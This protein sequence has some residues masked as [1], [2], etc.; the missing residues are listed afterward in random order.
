MSKKAVRD[1]LH[2]VWSH[3][4]Q[5]CDNPNLRM[6][7]RYGG[8]GITYC[9]EWRDYPAFHD[10]AVSNGYTE[11]LSIDRIDPN[12]NY[13]PSN[14][15][16]ITMKEQQRNKERTIY[17][18]IN[19]E[20]RTLAEWS[21]LYGLL[22]RTIHKR[23]ERGIRGEDLLDKENELTKSALKTEINGETHTLE[24][25]ARRSGV[26]IRTLRKRYERGIRGEDLLDKEKEMVRL[27]AKA[28][29]NGETHT[30]EEW[31]R[32]SGV[33]IR[34]LRKRY[35]RG[36]RGEELLKPGYKMGK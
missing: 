31:A 35:E 10:W 15:R 36:I 17:A 7:A 9:N 22:Y 25:W 11:G 12:G 24:E 30:L 2:D 26:Q 18:E 29:I 8:R 19:G 4:K 33:H 6:Y 34:T 16:W 20:V 14:C 1:K 28:E 23:Y 32:V 27:A 5:R 3:M 13:E 21:E